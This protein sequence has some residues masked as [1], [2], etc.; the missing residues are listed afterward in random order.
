MTRISA[1]VTFGAMTENMGIF[2]Q[3]DIR[4]TPQRL[5]VYNILKESNEHLTAEGIHEKILKIIPAVSLATVYNIVEILRNKGLIQEIKIDFDKSR[6]DIRTDTHHHF[7]CKGCK[8]IFDL[9]MTPCPAL[10][11]KE[12]NG[13]IIEELQGYFYGVCKDCRKDKSGI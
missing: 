2:K 7:L 12:I 11:Q 10:E 5:G 6:F 9:N 1:C 13:H 8:K 4:V 3:K